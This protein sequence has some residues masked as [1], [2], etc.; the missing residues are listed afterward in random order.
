MFPLVKISYA[1]GV[2]SKAAAN[3]GVNSL[4]TKIVSEIVQPLVTGLFFLTMLIFI[5]GLFGL[6]TKPADS[7]ARADAQRHV[8]WG[9][10]G[11]FIMVGV[12][13]IIRLIANTVG[14]S[15]PFS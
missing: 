11:M 13:G 12:Y 4:V 5:W 1:Q 8:L 9:V 2:F 7:T 6:F 14:V 15:D 3:P 10:I